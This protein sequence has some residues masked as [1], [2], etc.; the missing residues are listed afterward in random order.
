ML[1]RRAG[2][3]EGLDLTTV[4]SFDHGLHFGAGAQRLTTQ[5]V[6]FTGQQLGYRLIGIGDEL[7][8]HPLDLHLTLIVV[9]VGLKGHALALHPLLQD[10]GAIAERAFNDL[11]QVLPLGSRHIGQLPAITQ[12]LMRRIGTQTGTGKVG[13]PLD[14]GVEGNRILGVALEIDALNRVA[15]C[16]RGRTRSRI[17]VNL[18]R[19]LE[20]GLL[21]RLTV[22]PFNAR[23]PYYR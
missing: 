8:N 10:V 16:Q 2:D 23:D 3:Y 12:H 22:F 11:R 15:V 13:R 5:H 17:A 7:D 4:A 14:T 1:P 6:N 21:Q 20:V 19:Q 9:G 18:V